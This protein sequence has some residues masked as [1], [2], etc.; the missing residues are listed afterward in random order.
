M[1]KERVVKEFDE[2]EIDRTLNIKKEVVESKKDIYWEYKRNLLRGIWNEPQINPLDKWSALTNYIFE[3]YHDKPDK[4]SAEAI[5]RYL[6]KQHSYIEK[7][8]NLQNEINSFQQTMF[9][10]IVAIEI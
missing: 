2:D 9:D 4:I 6:D 3:L 1:I 5:Q 8:Q 7:S 10:K